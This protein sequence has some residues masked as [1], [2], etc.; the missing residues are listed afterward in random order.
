VAAEEVDIVDENDRVVGRASRGE[1]RKQNLRH[2][3]S[4]VLVFNP[5]GQLFVHRRTATK[6]V[7]PGHFDVAIGGVVLSGESYE[8]A[9]VREL[10]EEIGVEGVPLRRVVQFTYDDSSTRVNGVVFSCTYEG[11]VRLQRE[12]IVSG[13][14]LD[15]ADAL[16]QAQREPFCPDGLEALRRYLDRLESARARL[17]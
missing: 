8:S 6:D 10:S 13:E 9:A 7:Y 17:G 2:R 4:Y 11:T 5:L 12:E 1:I 3:A 16:M 15:L 14:W